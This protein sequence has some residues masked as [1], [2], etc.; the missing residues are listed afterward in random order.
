MKLNSN[1]LTKQ[2]LVYSMFNQY[3]FSE[4]KNNIGLIERYY[5]TDPN[6]MTNSLIKEL[7]NAIKQ[8]DLESIDEPLFKSILANQGKTDSEISLIMDEIVKYKLYDTNQIDPIRKHI[9][10]IGNQS[11]TS[12]AALKYPDD[13]EKYN[14][15]IRTHE[16]KQD[17][18]N[19]INTTN[20]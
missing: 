2:S 1:N 16:Y 10:N 3:V 7:L 14:E 17:L 9:R 8:Y 6:T 13:P 20:V 4:V 18:S 12:I 19:I 5:L 15:Y 11:I